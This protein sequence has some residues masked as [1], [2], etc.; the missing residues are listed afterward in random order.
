MCQCL[1]QSQESR[2]AWQW[3][4]DS[5]YLKDLY[6]V[7]IFITYTYPAEGFYHDREDGFL[8]VKLIH[9][10]LDVLTLQFPQMCET[11]LYNLW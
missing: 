5:F 6:F 3:P 8:R 11:Q 9:F 1:Q 7:R 10:Y 2:F 4:F